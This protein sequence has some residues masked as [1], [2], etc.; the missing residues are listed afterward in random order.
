MTEPRQWT[1]Y[2][3]RDKMIEHIHNLCRYWSTLPDKS[4]REKCDGL[5]FSILSML[6]GCSGGLP[7]FILVPDPHE[8]DE[9]YNKEEGNNWF[10]PQSKEFWETVN[11]PVCYMMHEHFHQR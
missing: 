3:V 6:D 9:S 1:A 7:G 10:P 2:E 8:S 5:A 11:T 4:P